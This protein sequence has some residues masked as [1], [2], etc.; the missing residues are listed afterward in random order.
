MLAPNGACLREIALIGFEDTEGIAAVGRNHFAILEER[1]HR[2]HTLAIDDHTTIR[3]REA[4]QSLSVAMSSKDN[5][6]L[7]GVAFDPVQGR[8]FVAQE[9]RPRRIR[10]R[11]ALEGG[12]GFRLEKGLVPNRWVMR[13]LSGLHSDPISR[14]LLL[15]SDE[16]KCLMAMR[17]DG[18]LRG[19]ASLR[20]GALGLEADIPQAKGVTLD[21]SG[22]LYIVSEPKPV[23]PLH[24]TDAT[25]GGHPDL[26]LR[27]E[28]R[29]QRKPS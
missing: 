8:V 27:P 22:N 28:Q 14:Q 18:G 10:S 21:G 13:D 7:E 1:R 12:P 26:T 16:S 4:V 19:Y 17:L 20:K 23:L 24:P 5:K 25:L 11:P 29:Q 15:L 3:W 9:K 2:L 6:G